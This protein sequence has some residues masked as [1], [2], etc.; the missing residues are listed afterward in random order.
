V[1][2]NESKALKSGAEGWF[3][4]LTRRGRIEVEDDMAAEEKQSIEATEPE[5]PLLDIPDDV[6]L[7]I[8]DRAS[9]QWL[10]D[11]GVWAA[12]VPD[13]RGVIATGATHVA[14]RDDLIKGLREWISFRLSRKL[15][16]PDVAGVGFRGYAVR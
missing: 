7:P 16:V 9:Y 12:T 1:S 11:D 14:C 3:A 8:A 6:L 10:E 13:F 2:D 15:T 5:F 4:D